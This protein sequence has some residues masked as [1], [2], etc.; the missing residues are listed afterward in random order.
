MFELVPKLESGK[1]W[2]DWILIG[3]NLTLVYT[4]PPAKYEIDLEIINSSSEMLDW[5]MQI[6]AKRWA[7][8]VI[9]GD[10]VKALNEIFLPQK[11]L[12][13]GG[14]SREINA[15]DLLLKRLKPEA[16]RIV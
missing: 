16:V 13:P 4:G 9:V 1:K 2:G 3:Q 14:V 10:L 5:I 15:R 7:T 6:A 8:P 12:C 11:S